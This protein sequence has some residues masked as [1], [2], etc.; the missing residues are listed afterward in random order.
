MPNS[1][2]NFFSTTNCLRYCTRMRMKP[3]GMILLL[4]LISGLALSRS[5]FLIDFGPP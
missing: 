4:P 5:F 3:M 2:I 1:V